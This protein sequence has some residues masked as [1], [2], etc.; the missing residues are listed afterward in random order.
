MAVQSA[1]RGQ[2]KKTGRIGRAAG[3][4]FVLPAV[5]FTVL[6]EYYPMLDGIFHSFYRWNGSTVEKF[7]GLDNFAEIFRDGVFWTSVKNMLFF[8][9]FQIVLMIPTI[10]A[11]IVLFRIKNSKMQYVYR[12]L[13]CVPM[14]IPGIVTMLL[15]Q[16][17]Y[18]PQYGFLNQLLDVLGLQQLQQLWLGDP[19]LA[20]WCLIFI[21]FPWIGTIAALIYLAGLQNVDG[22]VWD[23]AAIDGAGPVKKAL[24]IEL[25][26]LKGQFK[27]NL[28][29][30]LAGTV[31]GYGL[32]LVVT[33]GGPGF[34]TLVPGLYMYQRAFGSGTSDYGYASAVGL[35]LFVIA[36]AISAISIKY[37]RSEE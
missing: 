20:K 33:N 12:I 29:T 17:M 10:A 35:I 3:Y 19:A 21:G 1:A 30:V 26:L 16:F 27:L 36:L 11:C 22:S 24:F 25:P 9:F 4:G 13:L 8:L 23:A 37:I 14:I 6:F 15:W 32:Q 31:T 18:N 28:V 2:R 7:V 34:A 5:L